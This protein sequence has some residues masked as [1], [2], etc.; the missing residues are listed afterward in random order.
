M[1]KQYFQNKFSNINSNNLNYN[2]Y[3]LDKLI[4]NFL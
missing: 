2:L 4:I 3:I 1:N